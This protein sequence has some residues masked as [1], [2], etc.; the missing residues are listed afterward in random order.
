MVAGV[1]LGTMACANVQPVRE[2]APFIAET[3]PKVV[4]ARTTLFIV[5]LT[6]FTARTAYAPPDGSRLAV[7]T[8]RAGNWDV[9]V[10]DPTSGA[11]RILTLQQN[12]DATP[13]WTRDGKALWNASS[14]R[15][16]W[17]PSI[18]RSTGP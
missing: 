8:K 3:S 11:M 10:L 18:S 6:A 9:A 12:N 5:G 17:P 4:Y 15:A 13:A 7:R 1:L 16:A 14:A 2:P